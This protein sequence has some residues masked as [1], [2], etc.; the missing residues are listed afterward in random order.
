MAAPRKKR[1]FY[2]P[3]AN[4]EVKTGG[5]AELISYNAKP[6]API[7]LSKMPFEIDGLVEKYQWAKPKMGVSHERA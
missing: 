1:S 2:K 4:A 7:T 3:I 5:K 6:P